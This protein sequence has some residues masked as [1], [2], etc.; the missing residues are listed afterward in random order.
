MGS[1]PNVN[2][3]PGTRKALSRKTLHFRRAARVRASDSRTDTGYQTRGSSLDD[4]RD[5][6]EPSRRVAVRDSRFAASGWRLAARGW[7]FAASGW[8]LALKAR[9]W[10]L[11]AGNC[12]QTVEFDCNLMRDVVPKIFCAHN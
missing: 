3:V 6:P 12:C 8:R 5:D 4:A 2:L 11:E 7:R 9:S 1:N 10:K